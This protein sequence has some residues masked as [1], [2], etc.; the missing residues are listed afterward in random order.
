MTKTVTLW[1]EEGKGWCWSAV[2]GEC[3][4]GAVD[5]RHGSLPLEQA[6]LSWSAAGSVVL[7]LLGLPARSV[8]VGEV[9]GTER[10]RWTA[11]VNEGEAMRPGTVGF[12]ACDW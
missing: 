2:G 5:T 1:R 9:Q 4:V 6:P 10:E 11:T 12:R 8:W 7:T 3:G